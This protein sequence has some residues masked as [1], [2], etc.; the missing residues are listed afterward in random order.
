MAEHAAQTRALVPGSTI[1]M[2]GGGQ[3]GR[4]SALAAANLGYRVHVFCPEQDGPAQQVCAT[5]TVAAYEDEAALARFADAVDVVT[6]EFENV[7]D[8]TARF[9]A[10][11]RPVRPGPEALRV[12]QDRIVEKDFINSCGVATA[13][14]RCVD[15]PAELEAAVAA[16]GRPAVLKSTRLGYD[17]KGQVKIAP[18][19]DL[20]KAWRLMGSAHGILEGFVDFD[21][22]ISVIVARGIDGEIVPYPAVENRHANH[23]LDTT[24]APAAISRAQASEAEGIARALA[25]ALDLVGLLAIEMFVARSGAILVNELAPRPHNSGH[26]TMDACRT[27]QFEQFIRAVAGLPLGSIERHADAVMKNL[28]G[29]EVHSWPAILAEPGAKLHLYGKAEARRGRKMG[30]V[31]R[32]Y[33]LGGAPR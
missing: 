29:D 15:S 20:D 9:L 25:R 31:N 21:C 3:L 2:L 19:T 8:A 33:P 23:I 12:A 28:I 18:D 6:Y 4:M 26:W 5:A 13:P 11:R 22:E 14:Y 24:I 7:P 1:G 16:L 30:H 32:L 10:A 17:G 27:S